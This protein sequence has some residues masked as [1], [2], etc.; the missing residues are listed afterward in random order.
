MEADSDTQSDVDLLI[1]DYLLCT[2][3]YGLVY[4]N[5]V[6]AEQAN[7]CD[8]DWHTNAVHGMSHESLTCHFKTHADLLLFNVQLFEFANALRCYP[9]ARITSRARGT[10][11]SC[12]RYWSEGK[13]I[14]LSELAGTFITLCYTVGARL[15][16]ATW[17]DTAAQFVMQSAIDEYRKS[18]SPAS[19]SKH[20]T[21]ARKIS[22][23]TANMNQ[24][25]TECISHLQPPDGTSLNV[26]MRTVSARFP[27]NKFK[28]SVF[29]TVVNIMKVL[30]PPVLLQLE[31]GQLWGLSRTETKQLKDR[32][33]LK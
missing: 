23:Q 20:I 13:S 32:V 3:I 10:R 33:G 22:V 15:S 16:E 5:A 11:L 28:Y 6:E 4:A 9:D 18:E 8:F 7:E 2:S 26:H 25:F 31:R 21:W 17:A 29:D 30:E 24:A 14:S 19:L 12:S 27:I 1:L